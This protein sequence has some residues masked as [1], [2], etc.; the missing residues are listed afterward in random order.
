MP[1][2]APFGI[3]PDYEYA[4]RTGWTRRHWL[5]ALERML[6]GVLQCFGKEAVSPRI[7][8]S[9]DGDA[10]ARQLR[11]P[12]GVSEKL[13]RTMM[14]AATYMAATN[15]TT[16]E[17]FD[18]D[19]AAVYRRGI[20][21]SVRNPVPGKR[22][23]ETLRLCPGAHLAL[24]LGWK[25]LYEPLDPET[26]AR[27]AERLRE[28]VTRFPNESNLLLF[29]MTPAM[30]LERMGEDYDRGVSE[31]MFTR[32]LNMYRGDGWFI[33]GWN[34]QFDNYNFWG[35]QLYLHLF[36]YFDRTWRERYGDAIRAITAMHETT[37]PYWF[38]SDGAPIPKGRSLNY[39]FAAVSG[40]QWAQK[41]GLSSLSGGLARRIASGCLKYFLE[42]HRCLRD[43]GI[44]PIGYRSEN[45][46]V[47]E[48]YTDTGAPY[49]AGTGL[50]ALTLPEDH[51]FWVESEQPTPADGAV[52]RRI[53][54]RGAEMALKTGGSRGEARMY[55]AGEPFRHS[56][57]WQAGSKYYQHAYSSSLG[58]A[59]T[60]D[61]GPELSAGRTGVSPDGEVWAYRTR[62]RVRALN[63]DSCLSEWD[64]WLAR[65]RFEGLV[66]TKSFFLDRG[67]LH[68][69]THHSSRPQYLRIGG[70]SARL[71]R[72]Q[73]PT[74]FPGSET[75][76][77]PEAPRVEKEIGRMILSSDF[78]YSA[79]LQVAAVPMVSGRIA[80]VTLPPR[81][82]FSHSHLF[83]GMSCWPVWTSD[84]PVDPGEP[85]AIFVDAALRAVEGAWTPPNTDHLAE[86]TAGA[87]ADLRMVG[88]EDAGREA[89]I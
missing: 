10:L 7:P 56:T 39:R 6:G 18:G 83:G 40:I 19:I 23:P 3:P 32:I 12:G 84:R 67:E 38:A 28:N 36:M 41:S 34:Q 86:L 51:S 16:I 71:R 87:I 4:P 35:F 80:C 75:G 81:E 21:A 85:V 45:T 1:P 49:W 55:I 68:V 46:A 76:D 48:D 22:S 20:A 33:D 66:V 42:T 27:L 52:I 43:D 65:D 54:V 88:Q 59:L 29:S 30:I 79:M 47:G 62:P 64:A 89:P 53:A 5:A 13:N 44:L 70:W 78:N 31:G 14:L 9:R 25:H 11:N 58:F 2:E 60:G 77:G 8:A 72:N 50:V 82:G 73:I 17:G 24:L 61:L 63:A 69:F 26:K 74:D 15:R 37:V 57:I